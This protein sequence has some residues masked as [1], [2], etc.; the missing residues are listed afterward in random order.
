[1][2]I[3][4]NRIPVF[5]YGTLRNK[6]GGDPVGKHTYTVHPFFMFDG[7]YPVVSDYSVDKN[8]DN[9]RA[10]VRGQ[11]FRISFAELSRLDKYEGYPQ[12]YTRKMVELIAVHD[13][14]E[15]SFEKGWMYMAPR[16]DVIIRSL[17]NRPI[18]QPN[19]LGFLEWDDLPFED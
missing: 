2:K 18:V 5:V 1:M 3:N 13:D 16:S 12:L 17:L 11:L 7:M 19:E 15:K 10:R 9:Y 14:G 6:V 4:L 8:Q